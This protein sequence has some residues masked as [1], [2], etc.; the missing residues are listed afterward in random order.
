MQKAAAI[1][2]SL[3]LSM[4]ISSCAKKKEENKPEPKSAKE[5]ME[6]YT[7]TITTAP[8]KALA[9]G[10]AAEK[11]HELEEKAIKEVDQ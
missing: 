1:L 10:E 4:A 11:R 2:I 9:A 6:T 3:A 7:K 8:K 5:I